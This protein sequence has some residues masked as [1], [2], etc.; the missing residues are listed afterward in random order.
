MLTVIILCVYLS[1]FAILGVTHS[2][3]IVLIYACTPRWTQDLATII[4]AYC[5]HVYLTLS[6][7]P[8]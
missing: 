6:M 7:L 5:V 3:Y 4:W 1:F 8:A 2:S